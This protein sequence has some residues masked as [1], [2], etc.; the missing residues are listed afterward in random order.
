MNEKQ[1]TKGEERKE[2]PI[3]FRPENPGL[4]KFCGKLE[5]QVMEIIW[6]NG[7]MTVKRALYF[8]NKDDNYAY[9]TIMTVMNRLA[10]KSMLIREK[11][12]H[13]FVYSPTVNKKEFIKLATGKVLSGLM[14][15]YAPETTNI[16]FKLR[17]P[18][19]KKK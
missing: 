3:I 14:H 10:E 7:P 11:K 4:E 6:D 8:I 18:S 17:K 19:K 1:G 16:F 2:I 5:A 12:G 13:S 9:T 15:D